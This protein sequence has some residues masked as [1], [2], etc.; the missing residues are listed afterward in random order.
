MRARLIVNPVAGSARAGDLPEVL[1]IF[2]RA[3]WQVDVVRTSRPGDATA[4]AAEAAADGFDLVIVSG[5]DGTVN[6]A[7]QP[8]VGT[9]TALTVL[10]AGTAN[11]LAREM[12][13]PLRAP[14]A[15]RALV[16]GGVVTVDVGIASGKRYFLLF[17]GIGFDAAV[18]HAVDSE[19]KRRLGP[20][21]F[22]AASAQVMP[23]YNGASVQF[24]LDGKRR[25]RRH[26]LMA[27]V[28]NTRLFALF[29]LTPHARAHDG[30][31]DVIVFHGTGF[32]TKLQHLVLVILG[33]AKD[34]PNVDRWHVGRIEFRGRAPLP[35]ELD[36]EPWGFTPM[37]F[38][39]VPAAV[40]IWAPPTAPHDLFGAPEAVGSTV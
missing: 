25:R 7:L 4:A 33:R 2:E 18:I 30:K 5:G 22:V 9:R 20:F 27:V 21:S 39:V 36:G 10:P 19:L 14:E 12:G 37:S 1:A 31:L 35:V 15:A 29:P 17:A 28:A 6:E 24:R 3:G 23:G 34:A 40:R 38:A 26:V 11:L 32:W 13:L 16:D 8:L